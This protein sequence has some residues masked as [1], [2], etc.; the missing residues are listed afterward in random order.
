M[1]NAPDVAH[2]LENER[3][4]VEAQTAA[5]LEATGG[6]YVENLAEEKKLRCNSGIITHA[7]N[8]RLDEF[9]GWIGGDYSVE[10]QF[11]ER[12]IVRDI[13]ID[14]V[15]W[16]YLVPKDVTRLEESMSHHPYQTTAVRDAT[17]VN[18]IA[19]LRPGEYL[20][21]KFKGADRIDDEIAMSDRL[22]DTTS[23]AP[24]INWTDNLR[25]K[26]VSELDINDSA[27]A[28]SAPATVVSAAQA[29]ELL[30]LVEDKHIEY[31]NIVSLIPSRAYGRDYSYTAGGQHATPSYLMAA[32]KFNEYN[33]SHKA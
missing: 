19:R 33:G 4:D 28:S 10:K 3:D 29:K 18:E 12:C 20:D 24:P 17:A 32:Y 21:A 26:L 13:Q 9:A 15:E 31:N 22:L 8:R 23:P 25:T 7:N 5:V 27:A 30:C 2:A 14:P 6:G 1:I 16:K 11:I